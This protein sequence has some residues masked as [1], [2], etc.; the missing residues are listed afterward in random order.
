[1]EF[2]RGERPPFQRV[3]RDQDPVP[4]LIAVA[5]GRL[6]R[7]R[8]GKRPLVVPET[9]RVL[10]QHQAVGGIQQEQVNPLASHR[11][12]DRNLLVDLQQGRQA[13]QP[14]V[15]PTDAARQQLPHHAVGQAIERHLLAVAGLPATGGRQEQGAHL[16]RPLVLYLLQP[17]IPHRL[18]HRGAEGR[19]GFGPDD[20]KRQPRA[21]FGQTR[22]SMIRVRASRQSLL[23]PKPDAVAFVD[24]QRRLMGAVQG[25]ELPM[26]GQQTAQLVR[27]GELRVAEVRVGTPQTQGMVDVRQQRLVAFQ[28]RP[29]P[30]QE[31][32]QLFVR[33]HVV[34]VV[35]RPYRQRLVPQRRHLPRTP[36]L[37]RRSHGQPHQQGQHDRLGDPEKQQT[38][39]AYGSGF[40]LGRHPLFLRPGRRSTRRNTV[41]ISSS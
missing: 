27:R 7:L 28:P 31:S 4:Q 21:D 14:V 17:Q 34:E 5:L 39:V 8:L 1:M 35:K 15:G 41:P 25:G 16:D 11:R 20:R 19:R 10:R 13:V 26:V 24:Q 6:G 37:A 2:L 29:Q 32:P 30:Q 12:Q 38:G 9:V 40:S 36:K 33:D 22:R 3:S 23:Q 18:F